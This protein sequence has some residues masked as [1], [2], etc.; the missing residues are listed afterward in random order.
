MRGETSE[1]KG[2]AVVAPIKRDDARFDVGKHDFLLRAVEAVQLVDE[3]RRSFAAGGQAIAGLV[4][5][6]PQ[7]LH[8]AGGGVERR[9]FAPGL[10]GDHFGQRRF[11]RAGRTVKDGG[12]EAVGVE[13]S[14]QQFAG[15]EKMLLAGKLVDRA[16]PHARRQGHGPL[17]IF[18]FLAVKQTH[19]RVQV[20]EV[21]DREVRRVTAILRS[22]DCGL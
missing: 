3:Q 7:F 17:K 14:P 20:C 22:T 9:E 5:R 16:R 1:K 21:S 19:G 6:G 18:G 11:S 13:H 12:D 15:A 8:A 2:L 10:P 4:E